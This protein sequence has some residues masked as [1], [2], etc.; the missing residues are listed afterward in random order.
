MA[1]RVVTETEEELAYQPARSRRQSSPGGK[2][3][4]HEHRKIR[5]IIG[6]LAILAGIY[7]TIALM[8]FN[9][10]D[11]SFFTFSDRLVQNY[12]GPV[13]AYL[14]DLIIALVGLPGYLLPA[15]LLIYGTKKILGM[16]RNL[17]HLLGSALFIPAL[18]MLIELISKT[19]SRSFDPSGGLIGM[20]LSDIFQGMLSIV[21]A[22]IF[23]VA[24]ISVSM[25]LI[26]PASLFSFIIERKKGREIKE[27]PS[28][29]I[30][31]PEFDID[32]EDPEEFTI[33]ETRPKP[34]AQ[35]RSNP[36]P[37]RGIPRSLPKS[38][39]D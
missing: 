19:S 34:T 17:F 36:G 32:E 38:V 33:R 12:G 15:F 2:S 8:S 21:G 35:P 14:S 28:A 25:V 1:E 31:E 11:P 39:Q 16:E 13:G 10:W 18:A 20:L 27:T 24:L 9:K 30:E 6:I 37:G 29:L 3:G 4:D 5:T 23:C 22:Y 26:S 7:L